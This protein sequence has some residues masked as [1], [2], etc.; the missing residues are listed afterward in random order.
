[1]AFPRLRPET[2]KR[3]KKGKMTR[4]QAKRLALRLMRKFGL[5]GWEFRFNK[6]LQAAGSCRFPYEDV[7]G[8]IELSVYFVDIDPADEV[9]ETIRHEIA[10]AIAG[11]VFPPHGEAWVKACGITGAKPERTRKGPM[12]PPNWVAQCPSC[13]AAFSCYRKPPGPAWCVACGQEKCGDL[14]WKAA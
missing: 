14:V 6:T 2:K 4:D 5:H 10:H 9:E 8:R 13:Q 1:V 12:P 7:P 11:P 3:F